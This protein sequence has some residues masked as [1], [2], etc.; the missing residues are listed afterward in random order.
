MLTPSFLAI[1]HAPSASETS[2]MASTLGASAAA[3]NSMPPL[4][5]S[6]SM[7]WFPPSC[8]SLPGAKPRA[9]NNSSA[10]CNSSSDLPTTRGKTIDRI[11]SLGFYSNWG[12]SWR[13]TLLVAQRFDWVEPRRFDGGKHSAYQAHQGQDN[14]GD[15]DD[16]GID[17]QPDIGGFGILGNRAVEGE[18]AHANG[19][20][21][22]HGDAGNAAGKGDRQGFGQELK[23]DVATAAAVATSSFS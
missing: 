11:I 13:G 10:G 6:I 19:N 5:A 2:T 17:N 8:H 23:E 21:I 15:E 9:R 16:L 3:R 12:E 14:S 4:G 1:C 7:P 22:C 20:R 18:A